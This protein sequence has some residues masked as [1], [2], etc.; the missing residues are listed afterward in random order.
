MCHRLSRVCP[1]PVPKG[2]ACTQAKK[3]LNTA[4]LSLVEKKSSQPF[5][6]SVVPIGSVSTIES[7]A[8]Y[9]LCKNKHQ[10]LKPGDGP[11]VGTWPAG[12]GLSLLSLS[13]SHLPPNPGLILLP[14]VISVPYSVLNTQLH[15]LGQSLDF[16]K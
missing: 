10:G 1:R 5:L 4:L 8:R 15:D 9:V 13:V 2:S 7:S 16:P 6:M 14:A 12:D 11:S 3:P